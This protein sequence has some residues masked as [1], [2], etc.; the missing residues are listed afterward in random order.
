M[1]IC[2]SVMSCF[3]TH[4][5]NASNSAF[6]GSSNQS[7]ILGSNLSHLMC[8]ICFTS[9]HS[10]LQ[11]SCLPSV[12]RTAPDSLAS[13]FTVMSLGDGQETWYPN[14]GA[15]AHM[16]PFEGNLVFKSPHTGNAKIMVSN[17][18]LLPTSNIRNCYLPTTSCTLRL[19]SVF[20][21]HSFKQNLLLIKRFC[22]DNNC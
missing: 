13:S 15:S 22:H 4:A 17:G 14:S 20:Y 19:N 18:A 7:G 2:D 21:V 3:F 10:A 5:P 6:A 8:Q 11:H 1:H 9:T 12:A 16:T